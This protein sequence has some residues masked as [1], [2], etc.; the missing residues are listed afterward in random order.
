[1][2]FF[3]C[4]FIVLCL[5]SNSC[6]M[7]NK[8]ST[9]VVIPFDFGGKNIGEYARQ[10]WNTTFGRQ[11]NVGVMPKRIMVAVLSQIKR[12]DLDF[13]PFYRF[14][15][16]EFAMPNQDITSLYKDVKTAFGKLT[17]LKWFFE[18]LNKENILKSKFSYRHLLNTSDVNCGYDNGYI[19]VVLNPLLKPLFLEIAHYST[20]DLKWYMT[21]SSWYSMRLFECLSAYKDTGYWEVSID[22][23]RIIMDCENKYVDN[24]KKLLDTVLKTPV[25]EL[26]NEKTKMAFSYEPITEKVLGQKG[27]P[28]IVGVRFDLK[29]IQSNKIPS[30]VLIPERTQKVIDDLY[31]WEVS[32]A[33]IK[34]YLKA[35]TIEESVKLLKTWKD[36]QRS[37]LPILN[38]L[39][40]CNK[41]FVEA[42]K[43]ALEKK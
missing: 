41:A 33:N 15:I 40:Y 39:T 17:D 36:K 13:K 34:K 24:P 3:L 12:E 42:G 27:R 38:K 5:L 28:P 1:M 11:Q 22:E 35:I 18:E 4:Q 10:S 31:K 8:N 6:E 14:H 9:Q 19:T 16:S 32:E 26:G 20:F 43:K 7:E 2:L 21:F 29:T 25:L 30:D 37:N 23:F